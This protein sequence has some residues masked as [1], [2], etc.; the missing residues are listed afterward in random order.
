MSRI[1]F[2]NLISEYPESQRALLKIKDWMQTHND[3]ESINPTLLAR[4]VRG[5]NAID[6]ASALA[7]LVHAGLFRRVYK[8]L[9]PNGVFADGEFEDPTKI[10]SKL[11]DR[12]EH[13]FDTSDSDVVPIFQKVA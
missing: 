7:L 9:T 13:Y 11:P 10:P 5:I 4:E 6:L 12:W 2:D 8:V 1:N 3:I